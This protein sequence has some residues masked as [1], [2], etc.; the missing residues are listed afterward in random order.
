MTSNLRTIAE[1]TRRWMEERKRK[2]ITNHFTQL[3]R[4]LKQI[5]CF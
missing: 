2:I 5:Y 3:Y 1:K 4:K